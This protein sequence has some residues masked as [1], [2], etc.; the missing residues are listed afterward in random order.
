M[1]GW[2]S[3]HGWRR[4][5]AATESTVEISA[6]EDWDAAG[7]SF[8]RVT[9]AQAWHWLDMLPRRPRQRRSYTAGDPLSDLQRGAHPDDLAD[10]LRRLLDCGAR[11]HPPSLPGYAANRSTD[12]RAGLTP[13]HDAIAAVPDSARH[14]RGFRGRGATADEWLDLLLSYSEYPPSS[15]RFDAVCSTPSGRRS[16]IR[17]LVRHDFETFSSRPPGSADPPRC[18]PCRPPPMVFRDGYLAVRYVPPSPLYGVRWSSRN[19]EGHISGVVL[20][21][22]GHDPA[23]FVQ[24]KASLLRVIESHPDR[25]G[26]L[27]SRLPVS[28]RSLQ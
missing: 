13:V 12:V 4:S 3:R 22:V 16:M 1:L 25:L 5:L 26:E 23:N 2:N 15:L 9:S 10:A 18:R 8:D 6:F 20:N 17:R 7:R 19:Y 27:L 14:E 28:S 21:L 24:G 11:R